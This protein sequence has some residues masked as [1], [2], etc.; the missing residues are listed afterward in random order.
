MYGLKPV[1]F[2]LVLFGLKV[3]SSVTHFTH[4]LLA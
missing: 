3:T 4:G 1:P 2:S